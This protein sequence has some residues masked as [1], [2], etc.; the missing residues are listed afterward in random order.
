MGRDRWDFCGMGTF[1]AMRV[2]PHTLLAIHGL[3]FGTRL[4]EEVLGEGQRGG[5]LR[6]TIGLGY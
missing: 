3:S 5:W 4:L 6:F 1:A 2:W